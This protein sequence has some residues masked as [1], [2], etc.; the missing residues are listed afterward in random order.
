MAL[1]PIDFE[2]SFAAAPDA[3]M[4]PIGSLEVL[5][6]AGYLYADFAGAYPPTCRSMDRELEPR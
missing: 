5:F 1:V 4:P 6:K 3:V 2:R